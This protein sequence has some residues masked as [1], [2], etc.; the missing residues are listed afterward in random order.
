MSIIIRRYFPTFCTF[1]EDRVLE[2]YEVSTMEEFLDIGFIKEMHAPD[3]GLVGLSWSKYPVRVSHQPTAVNGVIISGHYSGGE[4][5]AMAYAYNKDGSSVEDFFMNTP[6]VHY[7]VALQKY[8]KSRYTVYAVQDDSPN[9]ARVGVSCLSDTFTS[10]FLVER[11]N[12]YGNFNGIWLLPIEGSAFKVFVG[13]DEENFPTE[14]WGHSYAHVGWIQLE[15][16]SATPGR[17]M[18]DWN[19]ICQSEQSKQ[20]NICAIH[21]G[22][23]TAARNYDV[24]GPRQ[25]KEET[26]RFYHMSAIGLTDKGACFPDLNSF[27]N[28]DYLRDMLEKHDLEDVGICYFQQTFSSPSRIMVYLS[29]EYDD[30]IISVLVGVLQ[31][32]E[33]IAPI[34]YFD[35]LEGYGHDMEKFPEL[36]RVENY[37]LTTEEK[38]RIDCQYF[39]HDDGSLFYVDN[40][41]R[42]G[43]VREALGLVKPEDL[44][45]PMNTRMMLEGLDHPATWNE[46][47]FGTHASRVNERNRPIVIEPSSMALAVGKA[48]DL[49]DYEEESGYPTYIQQKHGTQTRPKNTG[50]KHKKPHWSKGRW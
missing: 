13:I 24:E 18:E 22:T 27:F 44:T 48:I 35:A 43:N 3:C 11:I 45:K 8:T 21:E 9:P 14:V 7:D 41:T 26:L 12:K 32:G 40:E 29:K 17:L 31:F 10:K 20:L 50:G 15:G 6:F 4:H 2:E 30:K 39:E 28:S 16:E 25:F 47:N 49:D 5:Y 38:A 37:H 46:S 23:L 19:E 42:Q 36:R 1:S 34:D 33:S